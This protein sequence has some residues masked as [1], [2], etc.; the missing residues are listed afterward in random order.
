MLREMRRLCRFLNGAM[1]GKGE[2][3]EVGEGFPS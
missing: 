3:R 1:L 2:R